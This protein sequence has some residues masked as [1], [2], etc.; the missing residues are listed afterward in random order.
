MRGLLDAPE[1]RPRWSPAANASLANL[2]AQL[3]SPPRKCG[4]SQRVATQAGR[5]APSPLPC[6]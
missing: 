6:G 5:L 2:V 3:R 4:S 1:R